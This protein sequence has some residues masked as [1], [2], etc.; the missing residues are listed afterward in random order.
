MITKSLKKVNS[1]LKELRRGGIT[2]TEAPEVRELVATQT[3]LR[4][5]FATIRESHAQALERV[6][7][8][9]VEKQQKIVDEINAR[10]ESESGGLEIGRR[11]A[12]ALGD[13]GAIG[14]INDAQ[15]DMLTRQANG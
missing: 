13:E 1:R 14:R 10:Y 9:Q 5:R 15:R 6:F 2:E 7:Q 4:E 11:Y 3:H 8:A 12:T